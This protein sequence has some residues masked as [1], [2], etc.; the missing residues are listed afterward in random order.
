MAFSDLSPNVQDI[1][2]LN[3]D[4]FVKFVLIIGTLI[5]CIYL[6]QTFKKEDVSP[7]VATR[8][9]RGMFYVLSK[10]YI[11]LSPLFIFLFYPQVHIDTILIVMTSFYSVMFII[12]GFIVV[13]INVLLFGSAFITDLLNIGIDKTKMGEK[14]RR[15]VYQVVGRKES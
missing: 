14:I 12:I 7:F 10:V 15:E 8:Y 2:M 11:F 13:P 9:L 3:F 5:A 4:F 1:V 6:V